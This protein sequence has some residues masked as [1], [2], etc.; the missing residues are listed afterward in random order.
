M[1]A[2]IG[3]EKEWKRM[4]RFTEIVGIL[5]I[6]CLMGAASATTVIDTSSSL[7]SVTAGGNSDLTQKSTGIV[8]ADKDVT[9]VSSQGGEAR[10]YQGFANVK[11]D[12]T[13]AVTGAK[14]VLLQNTNA[15]DQDAKKG[16]QLEQANSQSTNNKG[17]TVMFA[18]DTADQDGGLKAVFTDK[19]TNMQAGYGAKKNEATEIIDLSSKTGICGAVTSIQDNTKKIDPESVTAWSQASASIMTGKSNLAQ[20]NDDTIGAT[21]LVDATQKTWAETFGYDSSTVKQTDKGVYSGPGNIFSLETNYNKNVA[22]IGGA[23][24]SQSTSVEV[25]T[26]PWGP[27]LPTQAVGL[28]A[29]NT[30]EVTSILGDAASTQTKHSNIH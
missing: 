2:Y 25:Y 9:V 19:Q 3:N 11:Q 17:D 24:T 13:Q 29:F 23:K 7:S 18:V 21:K 16:G 15:A 22:V 12:S 30:D 10:A 26:H 27:S 5:L 28:S 6:L 20:T 8:A 1:N 4:K 14:D